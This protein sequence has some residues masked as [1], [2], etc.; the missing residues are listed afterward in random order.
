VASRRDADRL[1]EE[2]QELFADLWQVPRFSGPRRGFRPQLDCFRTDDPPTLTVVVG[3]AG[4]DP[5]D[6]RIVV[7]ERILV[8]AGE[9]RRP[10]SAQ[11]VSY[12]RM[13]IDYGP[14]QRR[15]ALSENVDTSRAE[16]IFHRGLLTI[17]LPIAA[18]PPQP[19][20]PRVTIAVRITA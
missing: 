6:V 17:S 9:R 1:H 16:A 11:R 13:E 14:F 15:L 7:S 3:L 4:V 12:Q 5:E 8:I 19:Q 20:P 10:S 18:Q 2:L